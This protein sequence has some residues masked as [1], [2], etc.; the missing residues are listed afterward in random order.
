MENK[1]F[2]QKALKY[3]NNTVLLSPKAKNVKYYCVLKA[4]SGEYEKALEGIMDY[5]MTKK[6]VIPFFL[7]DKFPGF[8]NLRDTPEFKALSNRVH[9]EQDSIKSLIKQMELRGEIDL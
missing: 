5:W 7:F 4:Y 8:D 6:Y 2:F 9:Y 3:L 1:S